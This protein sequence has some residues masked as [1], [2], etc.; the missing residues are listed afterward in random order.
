M[1][2]SHTLFDFMPCSTKISFKYYTT[3][4]TCKS[5]RTVSILSAWAIPIDRPLT[6]YAKIFSTCKSQSVASKW[7][8]LNS[9]AT[10]WAS[11]NCRHLNH[12]PLKNTMVQAATQYDLIVNDCFIVEIDKGKLSCTLIKYYQCFT[13]WKLDCRKEPENEHRRTDVVRVCQC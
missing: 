12:L 1:C 5:K 10:Q 13:V 6:C 3:S 4:S 2:D 9:M 7:R 8:E 11:R